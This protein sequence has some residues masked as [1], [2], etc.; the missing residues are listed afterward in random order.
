MIKIEVFYKEQAP[1]VFLVADSNDFSFAENT[2]FLL[3][4]GEYKLTMLDMSDVARVEV[5]EVG[6]AE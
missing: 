2:N 1:E 6:D 4:T 5:E 3:I